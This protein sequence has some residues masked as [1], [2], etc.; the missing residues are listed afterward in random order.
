VTLELPNNCG[1]APSGPFRMTKGKHIL[2]LEYVTPMLFDKFRVYTGKEP[3]VPEELYYKSD[4]NY[5][6]GNF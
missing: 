1:I 4:E 2:K 5:K 6:D 3:Q